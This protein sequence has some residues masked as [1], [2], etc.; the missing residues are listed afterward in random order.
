MSRI[1]SKV[2]DTRSMLLGF[3]L[4]QGVQSTY[5]VQSVVFVVISLMV[6]VSIPIWVLE[7]LTYSIILPVSSSKKSNRRAGM[8]YASM[9]GVE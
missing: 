1:Y 7:D 9:V 3:A 8:P 4:S 5:M 6:W 2:E